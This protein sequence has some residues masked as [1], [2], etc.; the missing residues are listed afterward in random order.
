MTLLYR[1]MWQDDQ[2]HDLFD[3]AAACF[4]E[5][6]AGKYPA[7]AVPDEGDTNIVDNG[8][9]VDLTVRR[10]EAD[11]VEAVQY[12]LAEDRTSGARWTTRFVALRGEGEQWLWVDLEHVTDDPT[13]PLVPAAPGLVR[14]LI[15]TAVDARVDQ[16]RLTTTPQPLH[17]EPV[18][19]LI[20]NSQRSI[21][22]V[23]FSPD[24]DGD[25]L[26]SERAGKVLHHLLGAAHA[27]VLSTR[28]VDELK[29]RVGDELAVWGGAARVYLPNRGPRG[30]DPARHRYLAARQMGSDPMRP[31]R[32]LQSMLGPTITARRPP[33]CFERVRRMLR[34]GASEDA[35]VLLDV[36]ESEIARV[37]RERDDL[38]VQL[39]EMEEDLLATQLDYNQAT[40]EVGRLE[41]TLRQVTLG[42]GDA[43]VGQAIDDLE[44][45]VASSEEAVA[46][47]RERLSGVAIHPD[48]ARDLDDLDE[49]SSGSTWAQSLWRGLRALHL[50]ALSDHDGDFRHWC[51]HSGDSWAWPYNDKKLSMHESETVQQNPRMADQR[52][53]PID[54]EVVPGGKVRMWSHLKIA[55]G[56]GPLA[57]RV[58]F[59]D[60]TR[61][62]SGKV[63]V[64]FIGPHH[65]M[66]NTRTN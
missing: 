42:A 64:G 11:D 8:D 3:E 16:V 34:L 30:L 32:I 59:Y 5:W 51:E 38:K 7:L 18:G 22:L 10:A 56:G 47:A 24:R 65:Y 28:G 39:A 41:Y 31:A 45:D 44:P 43:E 4:A 49:H 62:S 55:E 14:S 33:R 2:R 50:Y 9:R 17:G 36:A 21:P 40:D 58:Y 6:L 60:D 66:E 53:L 61:G 46:L 48:A 27:V 37:S 12:E 29:E 13:R 20:M 57:P 19:G 35:G 52:L 15:D 63:H 54:P 1:A 23:V 25:H 26:A